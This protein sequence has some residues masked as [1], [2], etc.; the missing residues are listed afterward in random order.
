M[1]TLSMKYV[2]LLLLTFNFY[3]QE[4]NQ[5]D[6]NGKKNG[7]WRGY[8]EESKRVRYEGT[9]DH[10]IEIGTF[11]FFDDTKAQSVISTRVFSENGKVAYTTFF[12]QKGNIVSEGKTINRLKEGEWKYFHKES[13]DIQTLEFYINDKLS[14]VR[15]VFYVG[16]ILAEESEYKDGKK[17]GFTKIYTIK[18]VIIEETHYKNGELNGLAKFWHPNGE[19]D[20]EGNYVDGIRKGKWKF[21]KKGKLF[22]EEI[23]PK[24]I[25]FQKRQIKKE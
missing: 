6:S 8:F 16:G 25:K 17:N 3:S 22:K 1:K 11:K 24:Q 12:D 9:F 2:F 19:L 14:G 23:L 4:I 10:G 5:T 18:N 21:Y 7:L 13:K 15:K 20:A